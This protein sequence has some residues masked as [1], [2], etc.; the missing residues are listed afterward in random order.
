VQPAAAEKP[1]R[2][3]PPNVSVDSKE[4]PVPA[5]ALVKSK[6]R[7]ADSEAETEHSETSMEEKATKTKKRSKKK[8]RADEAEQKVVS[9]NVELAQPPAPKTPK[10]RGRPR[11]L[12]DEKASRPVGSQPFNTS[13]FVSIENPPQLMRGRTHKTDKHIAQEPRVEGPFTLIRSMKWAGFLDEV[14]G[15]VGVDKENLRING[16]S[17]GFQKQKARLPLTSEQAFNTLREQVKVKN[18]SATVIFVYHP[19]CKQPQSRGHDGMGQAIQFDGA[20]ESRW[21]RKVSRLPNIQTKS[22]LTH[23]LCRL[24]S[25][26]SMTN[27][28][29][30]LR[31]WRHCMRLGNAQ[32]TPISIVSLHLFAPMKPGT[33]NSTRPDLLSGPMPLY[34]I[35]LFF[36]AIVPTDLLIE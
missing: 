17:W 23:T 25:L 30:L 35:Y 15:W 6:K 33:S 21:G 4:L 3:G 5:D 31:N 34:V 12:I 18:G 36:N 24:R 9:E 10:K 11:K 8:A 13:V 2:R 19:I 20:D 26:A 1:S 16:L 28:L 7:R 32:S 27:S 29:P 22:S 14:A